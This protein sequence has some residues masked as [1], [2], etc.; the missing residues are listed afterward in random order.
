M[1]Y[2]RAQRAV[3]VDA[4][5]GEQRIVEAGKTRLALQYEMEDME[6]AVISGDAGVMKL[7]YSSDVM[8]IMT[9]VRKEWQMRYPGEVW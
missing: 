8:E 1:E 6:Q 4:E 9:R 7:D 5:T 2:P 3:I